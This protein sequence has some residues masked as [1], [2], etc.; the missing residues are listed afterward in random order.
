MSESV[1]DPVSHRPVPLGNVPLRSEQFCCRELCCVLLCR[2]ETTGLSEKMED[3]SY[4]SCILTLTT[5]ER[6]LYIL[7][8]TVIF[9]MK[10]VR[11]DQ[12]EVFE[13]TLRRSLYHLFFLLKGSPSYF[14]HH[15]VYFKPSLVHV[16]IKFFAFM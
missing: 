13:S 2:K 14:K 15:L 9:A 12:R 4:P 7:T 16:Y 6:K 3:V 11:S 10:V 1:K 8:F 5:K